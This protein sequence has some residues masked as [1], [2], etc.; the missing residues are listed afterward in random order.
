MTADFES[1]LNVQAEAV[2]APKPVPQGTYRAQII[3]YEKVESA[4][5]K[6]PGVKF[7]LRLIEPQEDVDADDL[8]NFAQSGGVVSEKELSHTFY[9]TEA[10]RF[11]LRSFMHE[12]LGIPES[13]RT[14]IA[15][16]E[17]TKGCELLVRLKQKAGQRVGSYYN[18]IVETLAL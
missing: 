12:A 18:E 2:E 13:G 17:D 10:S 11:M 8:A 16:L 1:L 5:K 9:V 4:Q 7:T 6:T 3:N 15:M 14:L